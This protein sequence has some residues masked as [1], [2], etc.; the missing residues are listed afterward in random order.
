MDPDKFNFLVSIATACAGTIFIGSIIKLFSIFLKKFKINSKYIFFFGL[1][2]LVILKSFTGIS[3]ST[4]TWGI[5]GLVIGTGI[6][7]FIIE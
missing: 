2:C 1:I 7:D 4:I 6:I 3:Y 5:F